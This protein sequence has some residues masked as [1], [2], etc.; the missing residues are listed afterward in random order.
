MKKQFLSSVILA[1]CYNLMRAFVPFNVRP[2]LGAASLPIAPKSGDTHAAT[3]AVATAI[4]PTETPGS[5]TEALLQNKPSTDDA[6]VVIFVSQGS[7]IPRVVMVPATVADAD[8]LAEET[9]LATVS[10][11]DNTKTVSSHSVAVESGQEADALVLAA[12]DEVA[13]S[14]PKRGM[15]SLVNA[16]FDDIPKDEDGMPDGHYAII[17]DQT[18]D[19]SVKLFGTATP[20]DLSAKIADVQA[21]AAPAGTT[22]PSLW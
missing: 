1:L 20:G 5:L 16:L 13:A 9:K 18:G 11:D 4:K 6:K 19:G 22:A 3:L 8:V 15:A 17:V 14:K 21:E 2:T 7:M 12:S 10:R